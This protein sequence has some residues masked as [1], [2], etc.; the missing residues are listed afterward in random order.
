MTNIV[1]LCRFFLVVSPVPPLLR[2]A[3]AATV[4]VS[5]I[6]VALD[7]SRAEAALTPLLVLQLFAASAA[8]MVPARRGHYDLLF[9]RGQ[10]RLLVAAAH[11]TAS[12]AP[13][14]VGWIVL[15]LVEMAGRVEGP[16][17]LLTSGAMGAV[18]L[19]STVPWAATVALPKFAGAIGWLVVLAMF[20]MAVRGNTRVFTELGGGT[21]WVEGTLAILVYPPVLVGEDLVGPHGLLALPA[22]L[23]AA[24]SLAYAFAWIERHDVPLEAAQ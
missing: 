20:A 1:Y 6:A 18:F 4:A 14:V 17:A 13:G 21:S 11:W 3:L 23:G 12:I 8:F 10:G 22:L 5:A 24:A 9:T 16:I 2:S 7:A 15:V 19:V